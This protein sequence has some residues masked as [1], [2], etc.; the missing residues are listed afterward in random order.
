MKKV[1]LSLFLSLAISDIALADFGQINAK[2]GWNF[3]ADIS[4]L[5]KNTLLYTGN[6]H[7]VSLECLAHIPTIDFFKLGM[8]GEYLLP[9]KF[10][11]LPIFIT[12]QINPFLGIF[13][14]FNLGKVVYCDTKEEA[15]KDISGG[16]YCAL[17]IGYEFF[18]FIVEATI[19]AY[20]ASGEVEIR[21]AS[22]SHVQN[23][24]I[25]YVKSSLNLGYKFGF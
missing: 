24:E 19:S 22:L 20:R 21:Q 5:G 15:L 11:F 1:I 4:S 3:S 7:S 13:I 18:Y 25:V 12:T 6:G 23:L 2:F 8:G 17:G 9:G 10:S 16:G 14:K